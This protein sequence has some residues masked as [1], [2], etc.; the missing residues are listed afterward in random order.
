MFKSVQYV[1]F[2]GNPDLEAKAR[3]ANGVLGDRIRRWQDEIVVTW[4]PRAGSGLSLAL[5]MTFPNGATG[6]VTTAFPSVDLSDERLARRCRDV[7][8]DLLGVMLVKNAAQI[9]VDASEP[10]GV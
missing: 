9:R 4:R 1:G 8:D 2:E 3:H 10:L 5:D 6:A 7:W